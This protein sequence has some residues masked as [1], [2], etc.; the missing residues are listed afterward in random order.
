[1]TVKLPPPPPPPPGSAPAPSM[2]IKAKE[3]Q[4]SSGV[5]SGA[6]KIVIYGPGG[7]GKSCLAAMLPTPL[8]ID[9]H[10][11]TRKLP[12][13]RV[14]PSTWEDFRSSLAWAVTQSYKSVVV[15]TGTD[16]QEL[17]A[18]W[19]IE[20]M[21]TDSGKKSR[22]LEGFGW[23]K[24]YQYMAEEFMKTLG[25]LDRLHRA[26][27]HVVLTTHDVTS[28]VP[29][30]LGE[31]FIRYEPHL[32]SGDKKGRGSIRARVFQWADHVL[33]IA[34]DVLAQKGK[35]TGSG[36]RTIYTAELPTHMAKS[37]SLPPTPIIY[38]QNDPTIWRNLG[39]LS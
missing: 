7:I 36:T 10:D 33:F 28:P 26:G 29:N 17:C 27:K 9:V 22:T 14:T 23:G 19:V 24:G 34:Y 15:D 32:F 12:V 4:V 3:F 35:A 25:D 16:A 11:G 31:D 18:Q 39:C 6:E 5:V 1:M 30:P 37:R 2:A 21:V 38:T 20:N 13:H 8:F